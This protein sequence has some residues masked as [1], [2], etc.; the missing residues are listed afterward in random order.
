M[1]SSR[2]RGRSSCSG[3]KLAC[4]GE[5]TVGL[6]AHRRGHDDELVP[7]PEPIW[8]PGRERSASAPASPS[9]CRRK[10][11]V[12]VNAMGKRCGVVRPQETRHA[13]AGE[14]DSSQRPGAARAGASASQAG[15][16]VSPTCA[17]PW[18]PAAQARASTPRPGTKTVRA[19]AADDRTPRAAPA[20]HRSP[21]SPEAS[22]CAAGD[23]PP[24]AIR[25]PAARARAARGAPLVATGMPPALDAVETR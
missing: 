12:N 4:E 16:Q 14:S 2:E 25:L 7:G 21:E 8:R 20:R 23:L 3:V 13:N 17:S 1:S 6:A 9:M 5:Q 11:C 24:A 18:R 19:I 22:G 15:S 10:N